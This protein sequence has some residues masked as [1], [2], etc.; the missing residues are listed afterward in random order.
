MP[1]TLGRWGEIDEHQF[2]LRQPERNALIKRAVENG[3]NYF[4]A[5][6]TEEA[7]NRLEEAGFR[8]LSNKEAGPYSYLIVSAPEEG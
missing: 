3:V 6:Q 5:T 8:I 7:K 4:D 1:T 2:G